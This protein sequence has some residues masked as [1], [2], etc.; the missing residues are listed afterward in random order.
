MDTDEGTCFLDEMSKKEAKHE[1]DISL[2]NQLFDGQ[3]DKMNMAK[4]NE[5]KVPDNATCISISVQ[6]QPFCKALAAM[7]R[8]LWLENGFGER[9]LFSAAKPYKYG[10]MVYLFK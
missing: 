1:S 8:T 4:G 9:F 2:L 3:G 7:K 6:P 5:R 10:H